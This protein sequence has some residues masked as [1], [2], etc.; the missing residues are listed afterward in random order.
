MA[1]TLFELTHSLAEILGDR[2]LATTTSLALDTTTLVSTALTESAEFWKDGTVWILDGAQALKSR[3]VTAFDKNEVTFTPAV[4]AAVASG[5]RFYIAGPD[6]PQH[7]LIQAINASLAS[8]GKLPYYYRDAAFV[9]VADQEE[10][11]LPTPAGEDA[12]DD[13]RQVKVALNTSD[14]Y[15]WTDNRHFQVVGD[16]L[17]FDPGFQPWP[18]GR[19]MELLY[20]REHELLLDDDDVIH[21]QLTLDRVRWGAAAWLFRN[22]YIP[23]GKDNKQTTDLLTEAVNRSLDAAGQNRIHLPDAPNA[24]PWHSGW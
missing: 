13:V 22:R 19:M 14:P 8:I 16:V 18:S 11:D 2:K 12:I 7:L 9:T 10:Y 23:S 1:T 17:R 15:D 5:V 6:F 20:A 21:Q 4:A 3:R 24:L